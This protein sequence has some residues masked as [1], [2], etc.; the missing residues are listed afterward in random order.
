[1]TIIVHWISGHRCRHQWRSGGL[2]EAARSRKAKLDERE[3]DS[4]RA[5]AGP[6]PWQDEHHALPT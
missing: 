2:V 1:M 4:Q 5:L 3:Q 6:V